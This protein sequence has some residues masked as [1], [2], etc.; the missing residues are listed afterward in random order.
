MIMTKIEIMLSIN[1][2]Y[3][4]RVVSARPFI[5]DMTLWDLPVIDRP[6]VNFQVGML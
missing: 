1:V 6:S 3:K 4:T 5:A 2:T